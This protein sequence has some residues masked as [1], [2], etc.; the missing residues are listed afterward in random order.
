MQTDR[1]AGRFRGHNRGCDPQKKLSETEWGLARSPSELPNYVNRVPMEVNELL[2]EGRTQ[3]NIHC[4]VCHGKAGYGNGLASQR[5]LELEQGTWVPPTSLH[6][7]HLFEQPDGTTLQL[8]HQWRSQDAG[9][10]TS[11]CRVSDGRSSPTSERFSVVSKRR[12]K[13]SQK[14]TDQHFASSTK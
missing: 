13:T 11:D 14:T 10:R 12:S 2:R 8:D 3:F 4:A 6:S 7:P 9:L 1:W 5:A